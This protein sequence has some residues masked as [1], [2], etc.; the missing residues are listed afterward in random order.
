MEKM[1][2]RSAAVRGDVCPISGIACGNCD[3]PKLVLTT[4]PPRQGGRASYG[5][6]RVI[7]L[8]LSDADRRW[9]ERRADHDHY[10]E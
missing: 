2:R 3:R 10:E 4:D 1:P 5:Y 8:G 7:R 9:A 6:Q